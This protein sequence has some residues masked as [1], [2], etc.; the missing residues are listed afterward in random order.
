MSRHKIGDPAVKYPA[1]PASFGFIKL[2]NNNQ[3]HFYSYS[4]I[5]QQ[6][7]SD[8]ILHA[9]LLPLSI[10]QPINGHPTP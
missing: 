10:G 4:E 1:R 5:P 6:L 9:E 2:K 8:T 7:L 3:L